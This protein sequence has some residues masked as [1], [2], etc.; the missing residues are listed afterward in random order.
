VKFGNFSANGTF[1]PSTGG[2]LVTPGKPV[3]DDLLNNSYG[4]TCPRAA[5]Q[6]F[7]N[8]AT[9]PVCVPLPA[10]G[11]SIQAPTGCSCG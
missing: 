6:G 9:D 11:I 8:L 1:D 4:V 3:P 10:L 2:S 5:S 7:H